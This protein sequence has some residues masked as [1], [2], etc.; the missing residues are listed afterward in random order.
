MP[1]REPA[2]VLSGPLLSAGPAESNPAIARQWP[3]AQ[4]S[5]NLSSGLAAESGGRGSGS[6]ENRCLGACPTAGWIPLQKPSSSVALSTGSPDPSVSRM[7][8]RSTAEP[9]SAFPKIRRRSL[10]GAAPRE[11]ELLSFFPGSQHLGRERRRP[12]RAEGPTQPLGMRAYDRQ[13]RR[14]HHGL[15]GTEK[16]NQP[17]SLLPCGVLESHDTVLILAR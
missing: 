6:C 15:L 11:P 5:P 13:V 14:S 3:P 4:H 2:N 17:A 1:S 8:R 16:K 9:E 12:E 7:A 10:G